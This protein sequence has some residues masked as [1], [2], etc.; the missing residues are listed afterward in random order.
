MAALRSARF[1]GAARTSPTLTG[2]SCEKSSGLRPQDQVHRVWLRNPAERGFAHRLG[3]A[4]PQVRRG[5]HARAKGEVES[6]RRI[7]RIERW[8]QGST[9]IWLLPNSKNLLRIESRSGS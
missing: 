8:G 7:V 9:H 3:H 6:A 1:Q 5:L 2:T 4:L